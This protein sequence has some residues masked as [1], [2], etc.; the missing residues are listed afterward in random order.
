MLDEKLNSGLVYQWLLNSLEDVA[1]LARVCVL[2]KNLVKDLFGTESASSVIGEYVQINNVRFKV[3]G[4]LESRGQTPMGDDFDS[5]LLIPLSTGLRRTFN[6]DYITN[7]RVK[8]EDPD[9][10]APLGDEIR[11]LLHDRRAVRRSAWSR[12]YLCRGS[13]WL[14]GCPYFLAFCGRDYAL[15]F[16]CRTIVWN[17]SGCTRCRSGAYSGAQG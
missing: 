7:I 14:L 13:S 6:Q 15:L 11:K 12:H 16:G 1:T 17:L 8:V 2:G 9:Q 5:R 10:L 4:V 3:K